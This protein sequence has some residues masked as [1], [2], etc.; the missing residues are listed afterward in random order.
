MSNRM[1][2]DCHARLSGIR[3]YLESEAADWAPEFIVAPGL[4]SAAGVREVIRRG[5]NGLIADISVGRDV[6]DALARTDVPTVTIDVH[7]HH[8]CRRLGNFV[9]I[10]CDDEGL[11]RAGARYFI[12]QRRF[13][14]FGF[15]D[16]GYR[17]GWAAIRRAAFRQALDD[18]GFFC[19]VFN[20][21]G[22]DLP[23]AGPALAR[24]LRALPKPAAV[25]AVNDATAAQLLQVAADAKIAVP[26][27]VSVLG[28]DNDELVCENTHPTVS[29]IPPDFEREGFLAAA[30]LDELMRGTRG[31]I[32]NQILVAARPIVI[33]ESTSVLTPSDFLV[34]KALQFIRKNA[35]RG[36]GVDDVARHLRISRRLLYLRF[37]EARHAPVQEAIRAVQLEAVRH[38]LSATRESISDI[39]ADCGFGSET[40]LMRLFKRRFGLTM[41][42]WRAKEAGKPQAAALNSRRTILFGC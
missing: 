1:T 42:E 27:G 22:M 28:S 8:V 21:T 7:N 41:R 14:S 15:C 29:S 12:D 25:M 4:L 3:R 33:R 13:H 35:C 24:W 30:T 6:L 34:R 38:R 37:A 32:D 2:S 36:I 40:Y 19:H 11:A 23:S 31:T 10:R 17:T 39:A 5:A 20:P 9:S 18:A 16:T 26:Q